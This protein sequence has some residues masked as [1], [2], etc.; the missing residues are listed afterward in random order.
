MQTLPLK[1]GKNLIIPFHAEIMYP[2]KG[3]AEQEF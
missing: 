2:E 1:V 3:N